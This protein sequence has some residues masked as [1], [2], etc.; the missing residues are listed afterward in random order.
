MN[1]TKIFAYAR[2]AMKNLFHK[3]AT[4]SYP[5]EPAQ[6]P[7]RMR[8]HIEIDTAICSVIDY[9]EIY[10]GRMQL[11]RKAAEFL[12]CRFSL[13]INGTVLL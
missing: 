3:P 13:V 11:S 8:G 4:T 1:D 6:F 10:F 7:E 5:F 9:F 12:G 2:T